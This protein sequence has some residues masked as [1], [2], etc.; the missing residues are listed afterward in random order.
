MKVAFFCG[1]I[2]LLALSAQRTSSGKYDTASDCTNVALSSACT[3]TPFHH[4]LFECLWIHINIF[5]KILSGFAH[6]CSGV[7]SQKVLSTSKSTRHPVQ[8]DQVFETKN[9]QFFVKS[10]QIC[11]HTN[12]IFFQTPKHI[13]QSCFETSKYLYQR[14]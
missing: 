13:Y 3:W 2:I 7:G 5:A 4:P 11:R 1:T 9:R 14:L 10:R 8:S 6:A 12:K